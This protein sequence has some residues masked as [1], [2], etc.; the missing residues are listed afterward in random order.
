MSDAMSIAN[1]ILGTPDQEFTI[2][3]ADA[4]LDGEINMPDVMF[5]LNYILNGIFP[6][7]NENQNE[8]Q[9]ENENEN[10]NSGE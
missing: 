9:N 3:K 4:N 6:D 1:Y 7:D 2:E 5:I 10:E 8:N